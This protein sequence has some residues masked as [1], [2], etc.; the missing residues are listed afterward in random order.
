GDLQAR[1]WVDPSGASITMTVRQQGEDGG[2]LVDL[3]PSYAAP[4]GAQP[5]VRVGVL[6]GHGQTL[7]AD[8]VDLAGHTVTRIACD[9]AQSIVAE[10]SETRPAHLTALG[11]EVSVHLDAAAYLASGDTAPATGEVLAYGLL[12]EPDAATPTAH[13]SGTVAAVSSHETALGQGFHA[14][15]LDTAVGELTL[16]LATADHPT[17]PELG[18]VVAGVCYLVLDVPDLW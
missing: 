9:L 4:A 2:V 12:G 11:V 13:L 18:N 3:V 10:V 7:A 14:V 5:G 15:C 16:C 1:R 6:V 17:A 8:L